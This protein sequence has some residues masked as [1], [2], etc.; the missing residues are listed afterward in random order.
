MTAGLIN[1]PLSGPGRSRLRAPRVRESDAL[2]ATQAER[3]PAAP[4]AHWR[5]GFAVVR[6]SDALSHTEGTEFPRRSRDRRSR[7]FTKGA[8]RLSNDHGTGCRQRRQ[9]ARRC[10]ART[11]QGATRPRSVVRKTRMRL[12]SVREIEDFQLAV[13]TRCVLTT[14]PDDVRQAARIRRILATSRESSALS[15]DSEPRDWSRPRAFEGRTSSQQLLP[16]TV[17]YTPCTDRFSIAKYRVYELLYD[18]LC[19]SAGRQALGLSRPSDYP[20]IRF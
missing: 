5:G 9:P 16:R 18:T 8:K 3:E 17:P 14:L 15:N 11:P 12:S 6:E 20:R 2:P 19:R 10:R 13:R 4:S 7:S 1:H